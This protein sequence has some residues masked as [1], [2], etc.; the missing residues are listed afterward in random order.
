MKKQDKNEL[1]KTKMKKEKEEVTF[2]EKLFVFRFAAEE[3]KSV[4]I[5]D[6]CVRIRMEV[7]SSN[8]FGEV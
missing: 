6:C 2:G 4:K 7:V 3:E 5:G 1:I 8:D